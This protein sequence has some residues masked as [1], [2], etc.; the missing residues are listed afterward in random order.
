MSPARPNTTLLPINA[1]E[2]NV[3]F[4]ESPLRWDGVGSSSWSRCQTVRELA[5]LS[6]NP[7]RGRTP[8]IATSL[9]L[10]LNQTY[11]YSASPCIRIGQLL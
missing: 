10:E 4:L 3:P 1:L 11:I 6:Y 2:E 5:K 7:S 9:G 8:A